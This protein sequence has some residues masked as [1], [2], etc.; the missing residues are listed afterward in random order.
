MKD[1]ED[2]LV[3]IG[4]GVLVTWLER[5]GLLAPLDEVVSK[6]EDAFGNFSSTTGEVPDGVAKSAE[7]K[8][9][10]NTMSSTG[11]QSDLPTRVKKIPKKT[12]KDDDLLGK[13]RTTADMS[14]THVLTYDEQP[15]LTTRELVTK[16]P[17]RA[18]FKPTSAIVDADGIK[19]KVAAEKQMAG[20]LFKSAP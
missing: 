12:T 8:D 10:P 20:E 2:T 13:E 7:T 18:E 11:K 1:L 14:G 19:E 17:R 4:I 5:E 15:E 6:V 3:L 16:T 9:D